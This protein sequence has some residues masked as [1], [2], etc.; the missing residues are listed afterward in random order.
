MQA[1][2]QHSNPGPVRRPQPPEYLR[3]EPSNGD[4]AT[5]KRAISTLP[6]TASGD[7]RQPARMLIPRGAD[8]SPDADAAPA[9]ESLAQRARDGDRAAFE[10]LYRATVDRVYGLCLRMSGRAHVAEEC[11]QNAYVNAWRALDGF[12]GDSRVLTWLHR[13][14]VNEVLAD[15]RREQRHPAGDVAADTLPGL[16]DSTDPDLEQAIQAL[17]ERMR[18]VFVLY[19][20]YGY[21]HREVAE[22]LGIAEGTSKAHYHQAR[23][24]LMAFLGD[25]T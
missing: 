23:R 9:L 15:Q 19:A 14:A 20:V 16:Q 8:S 2:K 12:R 25:S 3:Y 11:T 21:G 13:I 5:A 17:P 10:A 1:L 6:A 7:G 4:R 18:E 22:M 24:S